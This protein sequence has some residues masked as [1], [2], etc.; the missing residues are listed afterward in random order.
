MFLLTVKILAANPIKLTRCGIGSGHRAISGNW[1]DVVTHMCGLWFYVIE[2]FNRLIW[3]LWVKITQ[4]S[5]YKSILLLTVKILASNHIKLTRC[6]IGPG[7]RAISGKWP[8]VVTHMCG[9][10]FY[11]IV[12]FNRLIWCLWVE[13]TQISIY[14]SMLLLTVEILASNH[15]KLSQCG[16]GSGHKAISGNWPDEV[17]H[18]CG[19]RFYVMEILC[20]S[21]GP[22]QALMRSSLFGIAAYFL[23]HFFKGNFQSFSLKFFFRN[24]ARFILLRLKI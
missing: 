22:C 12:L 11:V 17:T 24:M 5:I 3:C 18:I 9:L 7:H 19:L 13:R 2:L 4:I 14:K 20:K 21:K 1:P 16:I 8:D 10:R 15:I 6:G 23:C